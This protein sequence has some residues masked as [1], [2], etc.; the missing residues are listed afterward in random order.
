[1]A[2]SPGKRYLIVDR[3]GK[4]TQEFRDFLTEAGTSIVRLPI[5]SPDLNVYA[6]KFLLSIK[7]ECL[8]RSVGERRLSMSPSPT[9]AERLDR[10]SSRSSRAL[11]PKHL[12]LLCNSVFCGHRGKAT[13]L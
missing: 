12:D 7:S 2:S 13:I 1:M 9:A 4:Y 8:D 11:L 3:D 10:N 6:E 5:R